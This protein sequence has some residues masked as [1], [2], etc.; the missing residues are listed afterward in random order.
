MTVERQRVAVV[1]SGVSGLTAA[2]LLQRRHDVT[3]FEADHRLGGHAHTH[4]LPTRDGG[5]AQ[6]DSGFIVHN[7]RTYPNLLRLFGELGVATRDSEM[8]MSVRCRGCGLEYAG[9][10]GVSGLFAQ[11]RNLAN[12]RYLRMLAEVKRFHVHARR[13]LREDPGEITLRAF[14]VVGGYSRYFVDHFLVP[15][16]SAV[17][18]AG[19]E[20]SMRY[21]ARYLF[22]FL[23]HHGML[24][25]TGSPRWKTVVGGSRTYVERAVKGLT[26]V[27]VSTPVRAL[28][29][30]A[31]HLEVRDDADVAHRFAKVV[32]AT[33]PDQALRLLV[34]PT[35]AEREV[36]GAFEYSRNETLLHTDAT[37]LPT[38]PA[39][40]ASWNHLKPACSSDSGP[41][42]VSYHM[43][44]LMGLSEPEDYV[45]T[46][47]A[48]E[49]V[50]PDRV[51][52]WMAYEHPIYTPESLAAQRRLP[53]L[54]DDRLAY[55]GAYHG[56]GFHEDGCAS[57][58]RAAEALGSRWVK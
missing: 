47:N 10:L 52:R 11:P 40:R 51:L 26:A 35:A 12:P 56:W 31:D 14:V 20:L 42:K 54:T 16:V 46:L 13:V 21:P 45:V 38:A 8:S 15:L 19:A 55:A 27:E 36:L 44:R 24:A 32:L 7:E 43:N 48:P 39:A 2:Y 6:V 25:V 29:R 53:E 49:E 58:V 17:W 41:V 50:D 9:A 4:D 5:L 57:G 1:G 3:L 23:H 37:V 22:E 33:H 30:H 34:D 28:V 18:S